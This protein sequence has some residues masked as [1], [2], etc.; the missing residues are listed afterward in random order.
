MAVHIIPIN[1][2]SKEALIGV[3][4]EFVTRD[5]TDY[6]EGESDME[7]NFIAVRSKLEKGLAVLVFDDEPETTNILLA[8]DPILKSLRN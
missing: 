3:I 4:E 1:R 2:L 7:T 8:D 5:G 6:G